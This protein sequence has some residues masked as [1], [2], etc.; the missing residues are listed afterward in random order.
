[1]KKSDFIIET[2]IGQLA[3]IHYQARK[4][5]NRLKEER[6]KLFNFPDRDIGETWRTTSHDESRKLTY[7][8]YEASEKGRIARYKMTCLIKKIIK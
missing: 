1:M 5:V 3:I 2:E 8:I 7:E 6:G 4:E